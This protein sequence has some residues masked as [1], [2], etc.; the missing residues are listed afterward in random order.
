[1]IGQLTMH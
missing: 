1:M